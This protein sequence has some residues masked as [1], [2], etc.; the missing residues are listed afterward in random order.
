MFSSFSSQFSATRFLIHLGA[1]TT[2]KMEKAD[3]IIDIQAFHDKEGEFLP[4]EIAVIGSNCN[5]FAH[6]IIKPPYNSEK[7]PKG[8]LATNSYLTCFHHGIEW[9]DGESDLEDVL[10]SLREVARNSLRIYTRGVQKMEFLEKLLCRQIINLEE[11][12]CPSFRNLP[13]VNEHFCFYHGRKREYFASALCY[14]YKL[15]VWLLK[16]L[17]VQNHQWT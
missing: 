1:L 11:Y 13:R 3:Y 16:T 17:Y 9:F 7:I 5:F 4:K 6:W 14:A 12:S 10:N 15:R 2:Y 8:I